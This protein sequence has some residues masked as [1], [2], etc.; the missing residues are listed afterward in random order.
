MALQA[1]GLFSLI[2]RSGRA[3]GPDRVGRCTQFV[4]RHVSHRH[5]LTGGVSRFFRGAAHLSGRGVSGKG[6]RAGL[7]HRDLTPR[8]SACLLDRPARTVVTGLRTLEEMQYV[9]CAIGRPHGKK[10]MMGV[11]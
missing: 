7:R 6:G 8:P 3:C 10:V 11:L 4:S 2:F 1:T 5:S 9:L